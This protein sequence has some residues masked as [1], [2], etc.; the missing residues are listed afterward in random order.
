[1]RIKIDLRKNAQK[2]ADDYYTRSKKLLQKTDGAAKAVLDLDAKLA[3]LEEQAG[4]G[5]HF[6]ERTKIQKREWYEA[7][8]WFVTSS[9]LLVIG[10]RDAT[11][12][13]LLNSRH[14]EEGDLFFH[15]DVFG[16]SVTILKKGSS[17][18][19]QDRREA[20][21]FAASYSSA[22]KGGISSIDVYAMQRKQVGKSSGGGYLSKGS[23]SL[24]GE[25]EWYRAI[26]L[27][28]AARVDGEKLRIM[29]RIMFDL[30]RE[31]ADGV[32][33][34][35]ISQGKDKKSDAA[36]S[37]SKITGY[38]DLDYIMQQLPAGEFRI[39]RA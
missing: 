21:Q 14:F 16:A 38:K 30:M 35:M 13:E 32:P 29:P 34:A 26:P 12:N 1:M 20:A 3:K 7:F 28:L 24:S 4:E 33:C 25:R 11:Q 17:A 10:G 6:A 9:G 15:A 23:F 39:S 8:H 5:A 22:W 2:N 36:K 27:A 18:A 31:S 19:E 37:I